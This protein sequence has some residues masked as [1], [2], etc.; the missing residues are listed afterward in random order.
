M[1]KL[2]K[3]IGQIVGISFEWLL[4]FVLLFTFAIRT[5]P[6]QTYLANIATNYLSKELNTEIKVDKISIVFINKIALD[7]VLIKDLK[8]DTL[9]YLS[10][11]YVTLDELNLKN[12]LTIK[13]VDV[14]NSTIKISQSKETGD[15]NFQFIVDYFAFQENKNKKPLIVELNELHLTN[16]DFHYDNFKYKYANWGVDYDHL[17]IR[18]IN[19]DVN[20]ISINKGVIRGN[21]KQLS[22]IENSGFVLNKFSCIAKVSEKGVFTK[23]VKIKTPYSSIYVP[24]V[25]LIIKHY[26]DFLTFNDSVTFDGYML[27]S[28]VSLKDVAYF[29]PNLQGM[30][31]TVYLKGIV[32][33][34]TKNLRITDFELKT[35]ENTRILGDL[36]LPDFRDFDQAIF[37]ENI[38]YAYVTIEDLKK[39]K[40]PLFLKD[41]Y[42]QFNDYFERLGYF[43]TSQIGLNGS[44]NQFVLSA[45]K[46][47][48]KLGSVDLSNGLLF[49]EN[50]KNNSY[51]FKKSK[52]GEFDLKVDSFQIGKFI[53]ND[54][55][56]FI[57]GFFNLSGE[58]NSFTDI[59]FESFNGKVKSFDYLDYAYQNITIEKGSFINNSIDSKIK[60]EDPNLELEYDGKID[61]NGQ[62]HLAFNIDLNKAILFKLNLS[63]IENSDLKTSFKLDLIGNHSNNIAGTISIDN[64]FYSETDK[65][66]DVPALLLKIDRNALEDFLSIKSKL[67]IASFSGKVDFNSIKYDFENQISKLFPAIIPLKK[68]S[69]RSKLKTDNNFKYK[70]ETKEI[71]ELL[72]VLFPDLNLASGTKIEGFYDGKTE[73]ASMKINSDEIRF[74]EMKFVGVDVNQQMNSKNI[75]AKYSISDFYL[76][77]SINVKNLTFILNGDKNSLYSKID[78]N[79]ST[80]NSSSIEWNT[81]VLGIDKYDITILPSYFSLKEKK[82]DI[83]NKSAISINGTTIDIGHFLLQ[84]DKQYLSI[85][86]R[87]SK[88]NEDHLNF[89]INDF[90]LDDFSSLFGSNV[91]IKGLVNGWGYLSNPYK[92][93]TYIGDANIQDLYVNNHEIGN[94][95]IQTQWETSSNSIGMRGDLIYKGNE[96]FGFDGNYYT[97]KPSDNLDFILVFD[98]TD[99]QFVNAFIDPEII[100]DVKGLLVGNLNLNGS[101]EDPKI[102]GNV[103]LVNG[104]ARLELLDV[105]YKL[106]GKISADEYGFY[107]NNMPIT[108]EEGNTGSI[109]GSMYHQ[110]FDN[111]D[112]DIVFNLEDKGI[113]NGFAPSKIEPLDKFLVM[114]TTY[115]EGDVYYGKGY[116][117]GIVEISGNSDNLEINVNLKTEEGSKIFFPMYGTSDI[118]EEEN[119]ISFKNKTENTTI[120]KEP[121]IDFTGVDLKMNFNV[122]PEAEIKIILNE[123]TGDEITATGSGDI[124]VD[125]DY[126]NDL[127]LKGTFKVKEGKYNFVMR[128]IN[129]KFIIQEN[130]TVTWTGDPYNALMDLKCYYTVNASLN[131]IS[132]LQ[133]TGTGTGSGTGNQ[134]IKCYLSLTESLLKPTI[135]FDIQAPKTNETGQSLLNRIKSD[136]DMLNK[137]FFS[138]LLFKKFQPIDGQTN[139]GGVGGSA[140]LDIAQSQINSMLSQ[141]S[142]DYKLNVGLDKNN[143]TSRTSMT[144]GVSK[145]FYRDRL[146][147]K[148]NFGVENTGISI[149]QNKN[150][151][152]GDVN[153][154]YILNEA[155]TFR[156]NI[157]NES[158]QNRI[159]QLNQGLFTQGTGVQYKEDFNTLKD[160]QLYN[161]FL[162]IF[163]SKKNKKTNNKQKNKRT[164]LPPIK[165][166]TTTYINIENYLN[167]LLQSYIKGYC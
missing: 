6:V 140:A 21:I 133:N 146:L 57:D 103:E 135:S 20:N 12:K 156:V 17:K 73:D 137:Q 108:D 31:Q 80:L 116:G 109:I 115:K 144:V 25:N 141:V 119:F 163:R 111:W 139:A 52:I 99:I 49:Q 145:G 81:S 159:F 9:A 83:V 26:T 143:I 126:L 151:P 7:G 110:Q 23:N 166:E 165:S 131:E 69:K 60:V 106:N 86:G 76:N 71:N 114:N 160:F 85:D 55:L 22:A 30:E 35:G 1:A 132:S 138:L 45:K 36:N 58:I 107:I 46:I 105:N 122:T 161:Y 13:K 153:L 42:I 32:T 44:Y 59:K 101:I 38:E 62:Q 47:K 10:T 121:K 87:I 65:K 125:L 19:L 91:N 92:N 40:L 8:N 90:K 64:L 142:K 104:N 74:K 136:P 39:F 117:T 102:A 127:K 149:N 5:S 129:Q 94:V 54:D 148:G 79:P 124:S 70:I 14:E 112:F 37:D 130:G 97:N 96:T 68:P 27:P 48:T 134:E 152:I 29:S 158:N 100:T 157:F 4:I 28:K 33:R 61:L 2:L 53:K 167:K 123:S 50:Q 118:N 51:Y 147:I 15:F 56:G 98:N 43:E 75:N 93:L 18:H 155:G 164:P 82:W 67:G 11:A 88:N 63:T 154:E 41:N 113:R 128:P 72:S 150:L 24:K 16:V 84:R 95:F 162:D 78:W 120:E 66:F 77:D 89:R 34:K 3:I